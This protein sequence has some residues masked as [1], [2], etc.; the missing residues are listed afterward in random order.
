M[1][2]LPAGTV[3]FLFT[4]IE[5]STKRWERNAEAM[6]AVIDRHFTLLRAAIESQN[7]VVFKIIGDAVQAAFPSAPAA[8][9]A[10]VD[11]G[12]RQRLGPGRPGVGQRLGEPG[13]VRLQRQAAPGGEVVLAPLTATAAHRATSTR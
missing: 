7:G 9:A 8:V 13:G 6:W 2:D 4:D 3:T 1:P 11:R 10:A 12:H 5:G